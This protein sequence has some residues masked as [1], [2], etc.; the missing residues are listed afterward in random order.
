MGEWV[1]CFNVLL[2]LMC[3]VCLCLL[4]ERKRSK[5]AAAES[6]GGRRS[7]SSVSV[8]NLFEDVFLLFYENILGKNE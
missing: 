3:L 6:T 1:N 4:V 8:I 7:F 5:A 2:V